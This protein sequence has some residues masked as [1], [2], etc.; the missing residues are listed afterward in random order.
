VFTQWTGAIEEVYQVISEFAM[1]AGVSF[2]AALETAFEWISFFAGQCRPHTDYT[3]YAGA[4][5]L[6]QV[7]RALQ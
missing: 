3:S 6:A 4:A 5:Y 7:A 1:N 2:F